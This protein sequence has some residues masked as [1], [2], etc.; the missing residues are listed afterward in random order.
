LVTTG[1][2]QLSGQNKL[3]MIDQSWSLV[4]AAAVRSKASSLG[5]ELLDR[6][7]SGEWGGRSG[8]PRRPRQS[9]RG[10][11]ERAVSLG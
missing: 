3:M 6:V 5:E 1:C 11:G 2:L 4:G 9:S 7:E 10:G 8:S